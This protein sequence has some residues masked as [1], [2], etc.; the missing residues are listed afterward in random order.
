[1][2]YLEIIKHIALFGVILTFI[3]GVLWLALYGLVVEGINPIPTGIMLIVLSFAFMAII[4]LIHKF[5]R[6]IK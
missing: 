6:G 5:E 4:I 3:Q 1:M 2:K